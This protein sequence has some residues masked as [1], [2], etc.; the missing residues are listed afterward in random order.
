M[1][2]MLACLAFL[3][4]Q[5]APAQQPLNL[6]LEKPGAE[7]YSRPLGWQRW[8][9]DPAMAIELDSTVSHRGRFSLHLQG[10]PG[11]APADDSIYEMACWISPFD[12]KGKRVG[13]S[14]WART[15]DLKGAA[16]VALET[17]GPSGL[18]KS[19]RSAEQTGTRDWN[20]LKTEL[21]VG[22]EAH[23]LYIMVSCYGPGGLWLDDL[24]F[25]IE[26]KAVNEVPVSVAFSEENL[27][28]FR[29]HIS[30]IQRIE[31]LLPGQRFD[32]SDLQLFREAAGKAR[33]IALGECTHGTH[34]F[35]TL[36][37]RLLEYAV[38]KL[39]V[40]TFAIESNQLAIEAI[41][42]YVLG[43]K[44]ELRAAARGL[45]GVYYTREVLDMIEW[46]KAYNKTYPDRMT[47]FVGFDM[48]DPMLPMDSLDRF[49]HDF[50][51]DLLPQVDSLLQPF[52]SAWKAQYYPRGSDPERALWK[53]HTQ[54]LYALVIAQ[55]PRW[56]EGAKSP[57][58]K[59]RVEW[60]IQN[61]R[62]IAQSAYVSFTGNQ[63]H[64]DSCMAENIGWILA[65]RAPEERVLIWAHDAHISRSDAPSS[66]ENYFEG[67]AMG[68]YLSRRYGDDY[69]AFGLFTYEGRYRATLSAYDYTMGTMEALPAPAGSLEAGLHHIAQKMGRP[70]LFVH[71]R[72]ARTDNQAAFLRQP[73]P[74]RFV[75]YSAVDFGFEGVA[76]LPYQFDGVFFLDKTSAARP[77]GKR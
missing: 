65:Q 66:L 2:N 42:D 6:D 10:G 26:G 9:F 30:P 72:P 4:C 59:R 12:L 56:M 63:H 45:F 71:L 17:Y 20:A 3:L 75:G 38:E 50:Q 51:P 48:Q 49:L 13:L 77:V 28:W 62:V 55:K 67:D 7:G 52:R 27:K 76:N 36:K 11:A 31:A 21:E 74:Y 22:P 19:V 58:E 8:N 35:F 24:Q 16:Y 43:G 68:G 64:R 39:G 18:I 57:A 69:R 46:L 23:S 34:E 25:S 15:Q 32:G 40:R 14:A 29:K 73:R 37:H 61:A 53:E 44:G 60:V 33:I 54:R 1:K 41:N 47:G 70:N 5:T